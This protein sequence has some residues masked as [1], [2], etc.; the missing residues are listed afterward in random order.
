VCVT[1]CV[2]MCVSVCVC[3]CVYENG[4]LFT[5]H[6]LS[7]CVDSREQFSGADSLL[8]SVVPQIQLSCLA[9]L[10]AAILYEPS[11]Q[12]QQDQVFKKDLFILFI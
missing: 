1:V 4:L 5:P 3:V 8:S 2:C 11:H 9:E 6:C 12:P 7:A 10:Q